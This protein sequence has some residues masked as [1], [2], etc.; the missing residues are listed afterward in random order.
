MKNLKILFQIFD[1]EDKKSFLLT[2][3]VS[4]ITTFFQFFGLSTV[5]PLIATLSDPNILNENSFVADIYEFYD[6][7]SYENFRDFLLYTSI[8]GVLLSVS[9]GLYNIYLVTKLSSNFGEKIEQ[10]V[11]NFYLNCNYLYHVKISL[12]KILSNISNLIP[13]IKNSILSSY[14][15]LFV[16][17]FMVLIVS[18]TILIVD[19][20]FSIFAIILV[21]GLYLLFF[22]FFKKIIK[23][24]GELITLYEQNKLKQVYESI[25]NIKFVNFIKNKFYFKAKHSTFSNDLAKIFIKNSLINISPRYFMEIILFMGV[26]FSL[27]VMSMSEISFSIILAKLSLFAVAAIKILPAINQIYQSIIN[28]RSNEHALVEFKKEFEFVHRANENLN[29]SKDGKSN[30]AFKDSIEIKNVNF[31][32]D[33]SDFKIRDVSLKIRKNEFVGF[34]GKTGSG[35]TTIVDIISGLY[36][37]QKGNL[38]VDGIKIDKTNIESFKNKIGY[39]PQDI[40]LGNNSIEEVISIGTDKKNIDRDLLISSTKKADIYNFIN[41]LP[42][43]F[44]TICG[45]RGIRLSGGQKQRVGIARALYKNPEIII[46]DESTNALDYYTENKIINT[47]LELKGKVTLIVITHRMETIK[48]CDTIFVV[49]NGKVVDSGKYEGLSRSSNFFKDINI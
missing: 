31:N 33:D 38:L 42:N 22:K 25:S 7:Q 19:F 29:F 2:I 40:Y 49:S 36:E 16:Q 20:Y 45:D 47:I 5:V 43:G 3:L 14:L 44:N 24:H 21:G 30:I 18:I 11:F 1:K 6:F 12:P 9:L 34:C 13:R 46:F 41:S 35:K 28:I 37:P 23:S 4:F 39:V 17:F 26:I 32:Y 8:I 15:N 48:N 27:I 10:K